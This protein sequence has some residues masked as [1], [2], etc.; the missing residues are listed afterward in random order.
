MSAQ[1]MHIGVPIEEVRPGMHYNEWGGFWVSDSVEG[2]DFRIEYLKFEENTRFPKP[3][4][5]KWHVAYRVDEPEFYLQEADEVLFDE[6]PDGKERIVFLHKNG[7]LIE[8]YH[9]E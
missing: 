5:E 6:S 8:L 2:H 9:N 7:A 1:Y 4:T 3:I